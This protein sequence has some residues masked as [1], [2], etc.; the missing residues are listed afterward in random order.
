MPSPR[1]EVLL[2]N[3]NGARDTLEC[4]ESVFA[5]EYPNFGVIVCDNA[6]TDCS[7]EQLEAW[8]RGE[9]PAP[10]RFKGPGSEARQRRSR[11]ISYATYDRCTA[12]A[13]GRPGE[14]PD[15]VI[16]RTGAN[17]GFAGGNNV[18]LRYLQAR[19]DVEFAWLLNNDTVT[20]PSALSHLV[21]RAES[22]RQ[23]AVVGGTLLDFERADVVQYFAGAN[24]SSWRGTIRLIGH[25]LPARAPRPQPARLDYVSGGCILVRLETLEKAGLMDERFFMYSEDADWCLRMRALGY[26]I[27][28]APQAEIWHKG[29]ASSVPG[30][31]THD[32]HNMVGSL[33]VMYKHFPSRAPVALAY[34]VYRFLLPKLVRG[35]WKRAVAIMRAFRDAARIADQPDRPAASARASSPVRDQD[36]AF[37]TGGAP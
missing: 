2:L 15:L 17:L 6:S 31:P 20:A 12:E 23:I 37:S 21:E 30:S 1:V 3:W 14:P 34:A 16:I 19:G 35:R 10:Q 22:D 25:G 5:L 8:A 27:A 13:G 7:V 11:P 9:L 36:A 24:L 33:L 28:F 4:L 29:G 18:G 32:Y 26:G